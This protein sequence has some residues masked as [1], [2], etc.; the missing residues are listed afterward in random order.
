MEDA[1]KPA[2][3]RAT[4]PPTAN[5]SEMYHSKDQ[6]QHQKLESRKIETS[7]QYLVPA[8]AHKNSSVEDPDDKGTE[9]NY[10]EPPK[11]DDFEDVDK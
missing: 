10:Y 11:A 9:H 4:L 7:Q 8:T 5:R 2:F 3:D 6:A 1:Q